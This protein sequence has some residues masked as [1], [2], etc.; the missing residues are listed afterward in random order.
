VEDFA[1]GDGSAFRHQLSIPAD[2]FVV[3]HLGRLAPEKNLVFL[4]EAVA[5]FLH[6]RA[7]THFLVIG[8]GPSESDMREV[9]DNAG[10]SGRLHIA[11]ILQSAELANALH[12]MDV[13]VFASYSETQGMVLTEAMAA[14]VP[15]VA[16]D[17]PGAREVIRDRVNGRLLEEQQREAFVAALGWLA[18]RSPQQREAL[19]QEARNTADSFSLQRTAEKALYAYTTVRSRLQPGTYTEDDSD[20]QVLNRVIKLIRAEWEIVKGMAEAGGA[21]LRHGNTDRKSD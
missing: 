7:D 16:L 6:T 8:S 11:G 15:V 12:A 18:G 10:L 4:A 1:H 17:A 5:G 21:A 20:N 14:G 13:F 2:A 19:V 9:F 3:G